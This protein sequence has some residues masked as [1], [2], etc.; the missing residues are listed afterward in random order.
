MEVGKGICCHILI[1]VHT[2]IPILLFL[3]VPFKHYNMSVDFT[4]YN[5]GVECESR[6]RL[7]GIFSYPDVAPL[8]THT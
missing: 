4:H 5:E 7:N 8:L 3:F 2:Y 6:V 1:K